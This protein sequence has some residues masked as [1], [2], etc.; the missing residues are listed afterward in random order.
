MIHSCFLQDQNNLIG[1]VHIGSFNKNE[2][3]VYLRGA[4]SETNRS[5]NYGRIFLSELTTYL[6]QEFPFLESIRLV[7][8]RDNIP[9]LKI[10]E[11]CGY[12]WLEK[13]IYINYNPNITSELKR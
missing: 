7:I 13:D 8:A 4:I 3:S 1:Y 5:K 12:K 10:A 11:I 6:F 9:S 2:K